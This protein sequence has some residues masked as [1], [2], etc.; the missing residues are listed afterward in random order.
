MEVE[1]ERWRERLKERRGEWRLRES[2]RGRERL[3]ERR[4]SGG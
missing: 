4:G 1:R 2:D 3:K